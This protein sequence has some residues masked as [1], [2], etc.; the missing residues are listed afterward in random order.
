[1]IACAGRC[2]GVKGQRSRVSPPRGQITQLETAASLTKASV[3]TLNAV[4]SPADPRRYARATVLSEAL[5]SCSLRPARAKIAVGRACNAQFSSTRATRLGSSQL[6]DPVD[7][8]GAD[9]PSRVIPHDPDGAALGHTRRVAVDALSDAH[10]VAVR[11]QR[12][13]RVSRR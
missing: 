4:S 7:V 1:M 3:C 10:D 5:A 13:E 6:N 12:I 2:T 8:S 9:F 11:I